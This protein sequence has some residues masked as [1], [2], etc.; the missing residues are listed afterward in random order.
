MDRI[1]QLSGGLPR[2]AATPVP[3]A[4]ARARR[5]APRARL[6]VAAAAS[7][8]PEP[9]APA[10]TGK[11][12]GRWQS[13]GIPVSRVRGL[14][15]KPERPSRAARV[16][17]D[18][19]PGPAF[20]HTAAHARAARRH[21]VRRAVARR[22]RGTR[23]AR[24]RVASPFLLRT[25]DPPPAAVAGSVVTGVRRI[26]KRIVFG[27]RGRALPRA[28]PDDRGPAAL[29][30]R[31][32]TKVA[33]RTPGSPRSTSR[34]GTLIAD[35]G[36]LARSAPRC[37]SWRARRRSRALDP[38]GLEVLEAAPRRAFAAALRERDHTLKRALTDPRLLQRHRQRLL[39]RDPAPRAP[40]AAAPHLAARRGGESRGS[41]TRRAPRCCATGPSA[42]APRPATRFPEKVTAFRDGD[43]GARPLPASPAP[44]AARRCS[45]SRYA[46]NETNYCARCQTGGKLLADRALSRLLHGD[47]PRTLEELE[48]A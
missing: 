16:I 7:K 45:G 36:R 37:T 13:R 20:G 24:V 40:L 29:A 35:R 26:G 2:S 3:R 21:G 27:A 47:W 34:R 31:A 38:G 5:A 1:A 22:V 23:L 41:S 4:R 30:R 48:G 25:V 39:R 43:G 15:R 19:A 46:E 6:G 17:S 44:S 32:G 14:T 33:G 18:R 28:A 42:C 10:R 8:R 12:A 9:R 11:A